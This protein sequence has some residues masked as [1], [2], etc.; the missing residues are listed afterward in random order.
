M[1]LRIVELRHLRIFVTLAEEL[2][3]GRTALRLH[4]T[5]PSV[6]GQ[7]RQLEEHLGVQLIRRNARQASLTEAGVEFLRGAR[8]V[9]EQADAA[10]IAVQRF[11]AGLCAG[12]RV[13]YLGD[14]IPEALAGALRRTALEFPK[15]RIVLSTG[16]AQR[17]LDDL[18]DDLIDMAVVSLPAPV[19]G[20]HVIPLGFEPAVAAVR[21]NLDRDDAAPLELLAQNTLL[22][23]PRSRNP[24]FYDSLVS[25]LHSAEIPAALLEVDATSAEQ[26]LLEVT[27]GS[28][29]AALV[30]ASVMRRIRVPGISFRRIDA[31]NQVGCRLAAVAAANAWTPALTAL[32]SALSEHSQP[33]PLRAA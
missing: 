28:D 31:A 24:A 15:T 29:C 6:S 27:C 25:A 13:G 33:L 19:S 21:A 9:L 7:L 12:L 1:S 10:E 26:L 2:H 8:R 18:R 4:L 32:A 23:L 20:L 11:Q 3:F 16:D 17:L 22:T 5:Q 14:A 30:P